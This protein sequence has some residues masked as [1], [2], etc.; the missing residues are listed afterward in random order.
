MTMNH[1]LHRGVYAI[2]DCVN[3]SFPLVLCTL[4]S[5]VLL[6]V[7]PAILGAVSSLRDSP[8]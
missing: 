8:L 3:L 2:T 5:F 4:P 7:A 1:A 6:S